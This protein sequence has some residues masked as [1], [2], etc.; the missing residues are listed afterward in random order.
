MKFIAM[1]QLV[2]KVANIIFKNYDFYEY[3]EFGAIL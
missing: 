1:K 2:W 3:V